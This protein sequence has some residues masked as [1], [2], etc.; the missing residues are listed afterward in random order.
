MAINVSSI[1][2]PNKE[3]GFDAESLKT[4]IKSLGKLDDVADVLK[5]LFFLQKKEETSTR[6]SQ[7]LLVDIFETN[8]VNTK[9]AARR[10][11]LNVAGQAIAFKRRREDVK[12]GKVATYTREAQLEVA[13]LG[14]EMQERI[15]LQLI[16]NGAA[17][18]DIADGIGGMGNRL[19]NAL[20]RVGGFLKGNKF[21]EI[22]RRREDN[23]KW[24]RIFSILEDLK[25]V[26]GP[27]RL[28]FWS[29]FLLGL[30][31]LLSHYLDKLDMGMGKWYRDFWTSIRTEMLLFRKGFWS[32]IGILFTGFKGIFIAPLL[33][34]FKDSKIGK[35]FIALGNALT[36]TLTPFKATVMKKINAGFGAIGKMWNS[37]DTFMTKHSINWNRARIWG[38]RILRLGK[39]L[40]KLFI[41]LTVILAAYDVITGAMKGYTEGGLVGAAVGA[42]KGLLNFFVDEPVRLVLDLIEWTAGAFGFKN[43]EKKMSEL[44]KNFSLADTFEK[45]MYSIINKIRGL[46][47]LPP[48]GKNG[49]GLKDFTVKYKDNKDFKNMRT[50]YKAGHTEDEVLAMTE[51]QR[52]QAVLALQTPLSARVALTKD[53]REV[54]LAEEDR[55]FGQRHPG[56]ATKN[57][58]LGKSISSGIEDAILSLFTVMGPV[59]AATFWA[60]KEYLKS[61]S[62]LLW[63]MIKDFMKSWAIDMHAMNIRL[64]GSGNPMAKA[65][66]SAFS[67]SSDHT[68]PRGVMLNKAFIREAALQAFVARENE[69]LEKI[70]QAIEVPGISTAAV[71]NLNYQKERLVRQITLA[72]AELTN[73]KRAINS[74]GAS[75]MPIQNFNITNQEV[76]LPNVRDSYNPNPMGMGSS[77]P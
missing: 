1:P 5:G 21:G 67:P 4:Q 75:T 76:T 45:V 48:I 36:K 64:G 20:D 11:A 3:N 34:I 47:G 24:M 31:L 66:Y 55:I 25:P 7:G 17:L 16:K 59:G 62:S 73:L 58:R 56:P 15:R 63:N 33:K 10:M 54:R 32:S 18:L 57:E 43:V 46:M 69:N 65:L 61:R 30:G 49:K 74:P 28:P 29:S 13:Y 39:M 50:L 71:S 26:K 22:E 53:Q 12:T 27:S 14:Y 19:G 68:T 44:S 70:Q 2:K 51:I 42:I 35:Q 8:K 9:W 6:I 23:R 40:G 77:Y 72:Q 60:T 37:L 38:G 41:P 52:H